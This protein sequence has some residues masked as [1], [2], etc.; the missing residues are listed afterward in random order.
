MH[1]FT[2]A[3]LARYRQSMMDSEDGARLLRALDAIDVDVAGQTFRRVPAGLPADHPRARWLLYSGLFA[4][5]QQPI[6]PELFTEQ[7]PRVCFDQ[8]WRLAPLQQ[9]LVDILPA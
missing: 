5:I 8:F 7:L 9:W 3:G 6:P 4:A 1:H 2:E